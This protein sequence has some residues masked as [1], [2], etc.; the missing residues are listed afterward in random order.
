MTRIDPQRPELTTIFAL[1]IALV[2]VPLLAALARRG[3]TLELATVLLW[4]TLR[5]TL[6]D[7]ETMRLALRNDRSMSNLV[8]DRY[9]CGSEYVTLERYRCIHFGDSCEASMCW[10]WQFTF[11]SID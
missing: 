3:K 8:L 2:L 1:Q 10:A 4:P 6:C 5:G 9:A 7:F 11:G